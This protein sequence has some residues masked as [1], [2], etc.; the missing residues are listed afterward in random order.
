MSQG[1]HGRLLFR[2]PFVCSSKFVSQGPPPSVG[3]KKRGVNSL[4]ARKIGR[5]RRQ[6]GNGRLGSLRVARKTM[7]MHHP[8]CVMATWGFCMPHLMF[9]ILSSPTLSP[10]GDRGREVS[11]MYWLA[12]SLLPMD[13]SPVLG[14][15]VRLVHLLSPL[16]LVLTVAYGFHTVSRRSNTTHSCVMKSWPQH[17][18]LTRVE[19]FFLFLTFYWYPATDVYFSLRILQPRRLRG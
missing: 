5:K 16:F 17:G 7:K 14:V 10:L 3:E 18:S 6:E 12:P 9:P 19:F 4:W 8:L 13:G 1:T 15:G 2:W 11:S